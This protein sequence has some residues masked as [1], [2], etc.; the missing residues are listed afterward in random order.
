M[1]VRVPDFSPLAV[2]SVSIA[3][4]SDVCAVDC[5]QRAIPVGS[6]KGEVAV[7]VDLGSYDNIEA[8]QVRVVDRC[9]D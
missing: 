3:L 9:E 7:Q 4:E 2:E 5:Q 1:N 6:S 8:K